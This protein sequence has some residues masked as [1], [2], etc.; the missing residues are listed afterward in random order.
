MGNWYIDLVNVTEK[1]NFSSYCVWKHGASGDNHWAMPSWN[2]VKYSSMAPACC[3]SHD[4]T[5]TTHISTWYLKVCR[6]DVDLVWVSL[7]MCTQCV[8]SLHTKIR[9]TRNEYIKEIMQQHTK[10]RVD[11]GEYATTCTSILSTSCVT[12]LQLNFIKRRRCT[13]TGALWVDKVMIF[14]TQLQA[15][16]T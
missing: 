4:V 1:L 11:K 3:D 10:S 5:V 16:P 9:Y 8:V 14:T 6:I 15:A 7:T 12:Q 13:N 2:W